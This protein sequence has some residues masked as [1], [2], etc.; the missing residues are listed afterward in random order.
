TRV[1][2][3]RGAARAAGPARG[4]WDAGA[5]VPV[6]AATEPS[7]GVRA[8]S[9]SRAYAPPKPAP[10]PTRP[11]ISAAATTAPIP[12]LRFGRS[13]GR[14]GNAGAGEGAGARL[15]RRGAAPRR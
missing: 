9:S 11:A 6:V 4:R 10:P 14:G 2:T 1:S 15:R 3:L 13:A 12:R 7:A 8:W 5:A